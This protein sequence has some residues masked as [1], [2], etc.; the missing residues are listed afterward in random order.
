MASIEIHGEAHTVTLSAPDAD[1]CYTWSCS[2]GVTQ[3][4][5]QFTADAIA[6]AEI[7]VDIYHSP[8]PSEE[9]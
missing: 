8:Y 3:G 5:P 6:E 7:H 9:N 4:G 1:G 2:C